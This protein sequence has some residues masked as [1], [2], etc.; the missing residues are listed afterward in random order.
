[1]Q[2]DKTSKRLFHFH[3]WM[4][5]T[6]PIQSGN[7]GHKQQW[8]VCAVCNKAQFRTLWWDKQTPLGQIIS[9]LKLVRAE[10]PPL[11]EEQG[12]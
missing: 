2:P 8:R 9:A 12:K 3:D 10:L 6:D 4:K 11:P 1:M 7:S 5:W